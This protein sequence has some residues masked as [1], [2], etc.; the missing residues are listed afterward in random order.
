MGSTVIAPIKGLG[1]GENKAAAVMASA[2]SVGGRVGT[3]VP[4]GRGSND[5]A[6]AAGD[7]RS[8]SAW[9]AVASIAGVG[10]TGVS[11]PETAAVGTSTKSTGAGTDA[12]GGGVAGTGSDWAAA[13]AVSTDNRGLVRRRNSF[14]CVTPFSSV[15]SVEAEPPVTLASSLEGAVDAGAA[16]ASGRVRD[17]SFRGGFLSSLIK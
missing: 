17:L 15:A 14:S 16:A 11:R 13:A 9:A 6:M 10:A 8:A 4:G 12:G 5:G 1:G 3:E 7:C 2:A